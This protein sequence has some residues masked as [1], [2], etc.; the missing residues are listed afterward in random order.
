MIL[1]TGLCQSPRHTVFLQQSSTTVTV[2][3]SSNSSYFKT[4]IDPRV[5]FDNKPVQLNKPIV[6]ED[7]SYSVVYGS[8]SINDQPDETSCKQIKMTV[9]GE[10]FPFKTVTFHLY[11]RHGSD[12]SYLRPLPSLTLNL[13]SPEGELLII[14]TE[15]GFIFVFIQ[16]LVSM[17]VITSHIR[18]T[19]ATRSII[20]TTQP[21]TN[22]PT[23]PVT[24]DTTNDANR[25]NQ[26]NMTEHSLYRG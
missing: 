13:S 11:Q 25:R 14:A 12:I 17:C 8:C 21:S 4:S 2:N 20:Y 6:T 16:T 3:I 18:C 1:L 26:G 9:W 5:R 19:D 24:K 22:E 7:Y 10:K 15:Y 23:D